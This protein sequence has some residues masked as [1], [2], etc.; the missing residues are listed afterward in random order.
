MKPIKIEMTSGMDCPGGQ[1]T[2]ISVN[3]TSK[4]RLYDDS[5]TTLDQ[6]IQIILKDYPNGTKFTCNY[7]KDKNE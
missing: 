6:A 4:G 1:W 2:N 5:N 7:A 3:G